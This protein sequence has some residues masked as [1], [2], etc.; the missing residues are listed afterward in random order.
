METAVPRIARGALPLLAVLL[1]LTAYGD[2]A[3][4][5]FVALDS[6]L[7]ATSI[8]ERVRDGALALRVFADAPWAGVGPGAYLAA[9]QRLDAAAGQV[10][11][12]PLLAAAEL[13][14]PGLLLV[15]ALFAGPFWAAWRRGAIL[16]APGALA[17]WVALVIISLFDTTLWFASSWQTAVLFGLVAS[18]GAVMR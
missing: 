8:T 7:E 18:T 12:V 9:A 15:L 10:H 14:L 17:P 2:L 13:G 6:T 16:R 1:L 11:N 5:R 3:L 4:S